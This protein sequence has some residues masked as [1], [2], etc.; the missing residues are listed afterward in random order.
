LYYDNLRNQEH[1]ST[2]R[3]IAALNAKFEAM[4]SENEFSERE[5]SDHI[6]QLEQQNNRLLVEKNSLV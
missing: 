5:L 4:A 2:A 6:L 1:D 3:Q